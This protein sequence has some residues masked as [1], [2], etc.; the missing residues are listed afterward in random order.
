LLAEPRDSV[1]LHGD[2][3]HGKVLDGGARGWLAIDPKGLIGET[4]FEYA[5]LFRN[6]DA[7]LALAPGRMRRQLAIVVALSGTEPKRLLQW[8]MAYAGLGAA[9][10]LE[11]GD[12][13]GPGLALAQIA[14][15][16]LTA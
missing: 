16:E 2:L 3:H 7:G 15:A 10:S 13:P 9:W 4:A 5:N 8:I 12:D 14:A 1:A 6:P 11:A